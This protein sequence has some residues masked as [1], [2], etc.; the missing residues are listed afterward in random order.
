[1]GEDAWHAMVSVKRARAAGRPTPKMYI[2]AREV[3]FLGSYH[4]R[5]QAHKS[6]QEKLILSLEGPLY[7]FDERGRR[8]RTR[9]CLVP[10]GLV[11][12]ESVIDATQAVVA[13]YHL[14]PFSQDYAALCR[15]M[16]PVLPGLYCD[17]PNEQAA[18]EAAV[19][20]RNSKQVTPALARERLRA[21]LFP[22]T[23]AN[24]VFRDF[25]PRIVAVARRIRDSLQENTGLSVLATEVQLSASRLEKLFKEQAGLPITQYRMRYR[26]FVSTVL[27]ALGYS[28]TEAALYAG[29]ASSAHLSR[30][31]RAINGITPSATF[32]KPPYLDPVIDASALELVECLIEGIQLT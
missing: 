10:T 11:V 19:D 29:F 22:P 5:Q 4:S 21:I 6:T 2:W 25:D 1:M 23:I 13:I 31:Y 9:S 15:I 20:I 8:I 7:V 3:L 26:V 24:G 14:A 30:S 18:I 28:I 12:D 16:K 17:H 32:L 27:M